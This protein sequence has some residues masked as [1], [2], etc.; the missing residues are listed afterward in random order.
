MNIHDKIDNIEI[1]VDKRTT[2]LGIIEILSDYRN[3]YPKL[4]NGIN[5]ED[6]IKYIDNTF[7][8][9]RNHNIIILFNNFLQKSEVIINAKTIYFKR[10]NGIR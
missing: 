4:I 10:S 2:L 9:Y 3:K 6:Y 8:K 1:K 5:N 7:S